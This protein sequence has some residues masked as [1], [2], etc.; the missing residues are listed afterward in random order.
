MPSMPTFAHLL[1][2][3]H[4]R[5][6]TER[7]CPRLRRGSGPIDGPRACRTSMTNGIECWASRPACALIGGPRKPMVPW[8]ARRQSAHQ[9]A[10]TEYLSHTTT[11]IASRASPATQPRQSARQS[12]PSTPNTAATVPG[13]QPPLTAAASIATLRHAVLLPCLCLCLRLC[14][15]LLSSLRR[16]APAV[17]LGAFQPARRCETNPPAPHPPRGS[18]AEC[19]H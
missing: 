4:S 2:A 5:T 3:R 6:G 12:A 8:H 13:L 16:G 15:L 7:W 17:C 10:H 18:R 9:A 19:T 14:F 11:Y 1:P